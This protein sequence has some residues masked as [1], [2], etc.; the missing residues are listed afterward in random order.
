VQEPQRAPFLQVQL[1]NSYHPK[2]RSALNDL[3]PRSSG[4]DGDSL[5]R[6]FL[7]SFPNFIFYFLFIIIIIIIVIFVS[8]FWILGFFFASGL[9]AFLIL[10]T[11]IGR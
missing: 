9:T 1:A 10:L 6:S 8:Q 5:E 4:Q 3:S 2:L 7:F 11:G